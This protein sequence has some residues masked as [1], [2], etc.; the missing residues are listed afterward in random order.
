MQRL[1]DGLNQ[2]EE[3]QHSLRSKVRSPGSREMAGCP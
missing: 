3:P 1:D 2:L